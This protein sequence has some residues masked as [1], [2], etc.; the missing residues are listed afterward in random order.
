MATP[1]RWFTD[2]AEGHSQ[3]YIE[4]F[5]SLAAQGADLAGEA[6]LV[7]ALV[8]PASRVLDAGCGTGRLAAELFRRGHDAV[9]VDVDPELLAAASADHPGPV[10]LQ[11]DLAELDLAAL[12]QPEPFAAAVLAGNVITFVAPGTEAAVL[13]RVAAH[14]VPGGRVVVGF[15]LDRGYALA[16]FDR[17]CAAAGLTVEQRFS[18]WDVARFT[19]ESDFAVTI[20]R[21]APEGSAPPPT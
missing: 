10:W 7:D 5:R 6:R 15:G 1:P 20:L 19:D 17:H 9:G 3:W 14:V 12:G 13:G 21:T 11:S 16:D 8:P 2:T 4:R 18:T